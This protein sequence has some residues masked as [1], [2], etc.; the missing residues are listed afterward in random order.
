MKY[1]A[2][3]TLLKTRRSI[4]YFKRDPLP[5][6]AVEKILEAGRWAMSGGNGQPWEFVIVKDKVI[7]AKIAKIMNDR[8]ER[9]WQV[10]LTRVQEYRHPQHQR[11]DLVDTQVRMVNEAPAIIIVC[12][13]PRK[14]QAT[15]LVNQYSSGEHDIF[16]MNLGNAAMVMNL[17]AASLG[18]GSAWQTID[19]PAEHQLKELLGIPIEYKIYVQ[20]PVGYPA[21]NPPPTYRRPLS[22]LAHYDGYDKS[23]HQTWEQVREWLAMLRQG[24]LPSYDVRKKARS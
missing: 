18:L 9:T 8:Q 14:F 7:R 22:D 19:R 16:H 10:E 15:V 24:S 4:R 13:D 5:E 12:G 21:F 20:I 1:D 6:G 23:K 11:R 17:A 3:L 2:F